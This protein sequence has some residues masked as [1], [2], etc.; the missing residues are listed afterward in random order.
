MIF[1]KKKLNLKLNH[2]S[3]HTCTIFSFD[4]TS[5]IT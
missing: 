4:K 1:K 5:T 2:I 3:K